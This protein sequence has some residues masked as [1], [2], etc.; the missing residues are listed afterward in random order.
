MQARNPKASNPEA[1]FEATQELDVTITVFVISLVVL[2]FKVRS[3][4]FIR[5][6]IKSPK[7]NKLTLAIDLLP[8][9][10]AIHVFNLGL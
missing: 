1:A 2:F 5:I 6:L 9:S 3:S 8:N 4:C 7:I 10:S